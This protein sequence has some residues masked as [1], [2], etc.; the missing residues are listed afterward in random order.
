[1]LTK[2][3]FKEVLELVESH[4]KEEDRWSKFGINLVEMPINNHFW[5]LFNIY[6]NDNFDINGCDWIY[7]YL[8]ERISIVTGK[9]LPYYEENSDEPKYVNNLDDLWELIKNYRV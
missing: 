1:M 8:W 5:E 3:R 2:E 7:W 9:I 4:S 6:I